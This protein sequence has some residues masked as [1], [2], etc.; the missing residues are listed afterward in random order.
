MLMHYACKKFN[1]FIIMI[2]VSQIIKYQFT[3]QVK[4]K[5]KRYPPQLRSLPRRVRP[6][7][8]LR[9]RARRRKSRRNLNPLNR[10][11]YPRNQ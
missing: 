2:P 5:P 4:G 3:K 8:R 7:V 1:F 10:N 6:K 9:V 11:Q